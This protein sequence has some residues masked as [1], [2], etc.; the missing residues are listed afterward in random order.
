MPELIK[1]KGCV[2]F[3]SSALANLP[4]PGKGSYCAA[5]AALD[6]V[7]T[8]LAGVPCPA[9]MPVSQGCPDSILQRQSCQYPQLL[10]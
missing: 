8:S 3:V 6:M 9:I 2:V 7:R 4:L 1:T 10:Y 5:K